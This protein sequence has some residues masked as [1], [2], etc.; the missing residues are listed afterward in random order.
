MAS[1][2]RPARFAWTAV[3]GARVALGVAVLVA[4]RVARAMLP[5][6]VDGTDARVAVRM[7]AARDLAL[8]LATL[9]ALRAG[10]MPAVALASAF[11]DGADAVVNARST[12]SSRAKALTVG[13]ALAGAAT[14]VV[15]SLAARGD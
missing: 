1:V 2:R 5:G 4:P 8:G 6:A 7:V 12:A 10:G 13:S 15:A 11:S 3:G 9:T 14:T